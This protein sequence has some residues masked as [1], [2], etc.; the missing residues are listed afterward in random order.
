MGTNYYAQVNVCKHC[1]RPSHSLH[2]GKS[3]GGWT[4]SFRAYEKYDSEYEIVIRSWEDWEKFLQR[5]DVTICDEYDDM[6]SFEFFRDVVFGDNRPSQMQNHTDCY[7]DGNFKD[8]DGHSFST[9]EF[10]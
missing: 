2:I 1:Q 8:K 3:S 9:G 5:P 4:F 10:S 7:P 6:R